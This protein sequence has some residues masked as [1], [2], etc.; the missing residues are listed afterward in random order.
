[1]KSHQKII[2]LFVA[3]T[4]LLGSLGWIAGIQA[5]QAPMVTQTSP[6]IA[7]VALADTEI[8]LLVPL[9]PFPGYQ[10][11]VSWNG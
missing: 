6:G 3:L 4:L 10:P 2:I 5:V 1:M 8:A 7:Q 11:N 9:Y